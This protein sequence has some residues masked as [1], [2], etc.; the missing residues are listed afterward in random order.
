MSLIFALFYFVSDLKAAHL[1]VTFSAAF[2]A[3]FAV[4]FVVAK[5]IS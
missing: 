3:A 4:A 2:S 1:L 5:A